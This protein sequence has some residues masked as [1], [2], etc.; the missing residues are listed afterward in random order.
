MIDFFLYNA[1]TTPY[2]LIPRQVPLLF[3]GIALFG[4]VITFRDIS[5]SPVRIF[6]FF[7]LENIYARSVTGI[8]KIERRA[9]SCINF[10]TSLRDTAVEFCFGTD[11]R[12]FS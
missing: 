2:S 6:Q 11:F 12:V 4:I 9:T 5:N 8:A 1:C 7:I 10:I 3:I